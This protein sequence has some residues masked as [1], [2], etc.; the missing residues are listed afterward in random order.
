MLPPEQESSGPTN[1][2]AHTIGDSFFIDLLDAIGSVRVVHGCQ[3]SFLPDSP[4]HFVFNSL[5]IHVGLLANISPQDDNTKR[6]WGF[7]ETSLDAIRGCKDKIS[8]I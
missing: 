5:E 8:A 6:I 3:G 2:H 7:L 4:P 1:C